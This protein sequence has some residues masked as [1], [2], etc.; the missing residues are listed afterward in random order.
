MKQRILSTAFWMKAM[1]WLLLIMFVFTIVSKAAAS[2]TVAQVKVDNPSSRK[3][4]YTMEAEGRIGKN[5]EISVLCQQDDLLIQSVMV[6]EGQ[7]VEKGEVLAKLDAANVKEQMKSLENKKQAFVLQN[8]EYQEIQAQEQGKRNQEIV[9][10]KED[11]ALARKKNASAVALA[12]KELTQARLRLKKA[13]EGK[14][15]SGKKAAA[16]CKMEVQEKKNALEDALETKRT[17]EKAAKRALEDASAHSSA[18]SRIGVNR[19]SIWEVN[20]EIGKLQK[21]IEQKYRITAPEDGV[22]TSVLVNVGQKT[23]D[24]AVFTMTDDSAGVKFT[25]Q[26]DLEDSKYISAGDSITL[27]NENKTLEDVKITTM[28]I[29]ESRQFMNVTAILPAKTF[30]L[31]ETVSMIV[32][33]ESENYSCTIPVTA[34]HQENSKYYV[35][36]METQDTVLG[37]Q[38]IAVKMEV[39][40][41]ERNGQFAALDSGTAPL[42]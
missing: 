39:S 16:A 37:Q 19:I 26:L 9:R 12:R 13:R 42:F 1:L 28:D 34:V 41:L 7:R 15:D 18:D 5:R 25:G 40:V 20:A 3:L 8:Q 27:K 29:D 36:L 4:I 17:E 21:V 33:Q 32:E 30:S 10:A 23:P 11:Y 6:S 31:G 22:I 38:T 14:N 2:F 24:S 35:F